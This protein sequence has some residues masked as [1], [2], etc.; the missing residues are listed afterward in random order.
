MASIF[1]GATNKSINV[2]DGYRPV[3]FNKNDI[4]TTC[5]LTLNSK[6]NFCDILT[7]IT[8]ISDGNVTVD[9]QIKLLISSNFVSQFYFE[10]LIV[11]NKNN[12]TAISFDFTKCKHVYDSEYDGIPLSAIANDVTIRLIGKDLEGFDN[13]FLQG[14]CFNTSTHNYALYDLNSGNLLENPT[15]KGFDLI[16]NI[17]DVNK[18]KQVRMYDKSYPYFYNVKQKYNCLNGVSNGKFYSGKFYIAV[19]NVI[20]KLEI[21]TSTPNSITD[22]DECIDTLQVSMCDRDYVP[23]SDAF[24]FWNNVNRSYIIDFG[25]FNFVGAGECRIGLSL[26]LLKDCNIVVTHD[27]NVEICFKDGVLCV[28][29]SC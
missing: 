18:A 24:L 1:S 13:C 14:K 28:P 4:N 12:K 5:S 7:N 25:S 20:N 23:N 10:D 2:Y 8:F 3:S 29:Y 9:N 11:T 16:S 21:I 26:R 6:N 15:I 22:S 17:F 19:S 27:Y